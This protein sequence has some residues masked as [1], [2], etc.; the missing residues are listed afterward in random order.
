MNKKWTIGI[1]QNRTTGAYYY[2]IS[3]STDFGVKTMGEFFDTI[4]ELFN[5]IKETIKQDEI[6]SLKSIK[7]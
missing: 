2:W 4:E 3:N 1:E 5:H 7:E 6:R